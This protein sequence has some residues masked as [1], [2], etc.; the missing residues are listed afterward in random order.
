MKKDYTL[1]FFFWD[2]IGNI[3]LICGDLNNNNRNIS[4]CQ[5]I[6]FRKLFAFYCLYHFNHTCHNSFDHPIIYYLL[7]C[8]FNRDNQFCDFTNNS[9]EFRVIIGLSYEFIIRLANWFHSLVFY[10][11]LFHYIKINIIW[12]HETKH[13]IE[14]YGW[15]M[16][17]GSFNL[18][19]WSTW[20]RVCLIR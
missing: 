5:I 2:F 17:S 11:V 14:N 16:Y 1:F 3:I 9:N 10:P 6:W 19:T 7:N 18:M 15:H 20:K 13:R 8:I 4:S 12:Y